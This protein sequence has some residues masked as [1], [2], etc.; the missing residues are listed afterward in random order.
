MHCASSVTRKVPFPK[1]TPALLRWASKCRFTPVAERWVEGL[2]AATHRS[3]RSSPHAGPLHVVYHS[4]LPMVRAFLRGSYTDMKLL[5]RLAEY[6]N[7]I[8]Q[9]AQMLKALDLEAH[10]AFQHALE[11]KVSLNKNS[12]LKTIARVTF[13]C[14]AESHFRTFPTTLRS[15][16]FARHPAANLPVLAEHGHARQTEVEAIW[17]HIALMHFKD[18]VSESAE[19]RS[20]V[21][22]LGPLKDG[23]TVPLQDV[24]NPCPHAVG[25]EDWQAQSV[26]GSTAPF[27]SQSV[28]DMYFFRVLHLDP[29]R[30]VL[31]KYAPKVQG[32]A[33]IVLVTLRCL[34]ID[35]VH[36]ELH[37]DIDSTTTSSHLQ[38][39]FQAECAKV[40]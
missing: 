25:V 38:D 5:P 36:G 21:Y 30:V 17:A 24:L 27:R 8:R 40:T 22:S 3:L 9:P 7:A 23:S 11:S 34:K 19:N 10:P 2:H 31:P 16:N 39:V 29:G 28:G 14:D 6:C 37:I 1:E 13:H 32:A 15:G 4:V 12:M 35:R 18:Y 33:S 20:A 26:D